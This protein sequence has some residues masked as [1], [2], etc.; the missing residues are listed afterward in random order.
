MAM[1]GIPMS[2][3]TGFLIVKATKSGSLITVEPG[4]VMSRGAG[5]LITMAA[6]CGPAAPGVGGLGRS[7]PIIVRSGLRLTCRSGAGAVVGA[8]V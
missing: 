2:P 7:I 6:G 4:L 1:C 5:R 8:S 3:R